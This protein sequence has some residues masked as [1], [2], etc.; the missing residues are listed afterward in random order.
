MVVSY[1]TYNIAQNTEALIGSGGFKWG[2]GGGRPLLAQNF[3]K[4][5]IFLFLMKFIVCICDIW[6]RG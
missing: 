3:F 1:T 6:R 5:R 2:G 4:S